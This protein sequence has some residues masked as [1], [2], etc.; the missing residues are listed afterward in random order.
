M[1]L[2]ILQ[3]APPQDVADAAG[4]PYHG[5]SAAPPAAA[6][7]PTAARSVMPTAGT[8]RGSGPICPDELYRSSKKHRV[9]HPMQSQQLALGR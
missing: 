1:C 9:Q 7:A 3:F 8:R 4:N 2:S 6:A 5:A